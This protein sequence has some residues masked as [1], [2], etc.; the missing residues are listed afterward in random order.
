MGWCATAC[1]VNRAVVMCL[2]GRTNAPIT[3]EIDRRIRI[4]HPFHPLSGKQFDLLEHRRIYSESYLYFHDDCDEVRVIPAIW[5][6]FGKM[7]AFVEMA[8]RTSPLH[9][10]CLLEL[11]DLVQRMGRKKDA[12]V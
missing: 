3:P 8:A 6:D 4:T 11:A 9:A 10:R 1:Y 7:D 5:T 2:N 12:D